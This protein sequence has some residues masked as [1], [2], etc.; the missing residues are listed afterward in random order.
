M[1]H[2][3]LVEALCSDRIPAE[4]PANELS[5]H[6]ILLQLQDNPE[7][8]SQYQRLV[9]KWRREH[10][11]FWSGRMFD[12][13]AEQSTGSES[14]APATLLSGRDGHSAANS[15]SSR[16]QQPKKILRRAVRRHIPSTPSSPSRLRRAPCES[17]EGVRSEVNVGGSSPTSM[18]YRSEKS[19]EFLFTAV[20]TS[21]TGS[22]RSS[23]SGER[24]SQRTSHSASTSRRG[25]GGGREQ[26]TLAVRQQDS[27]GSNSGAILPAFGLNFDRQ[28]VAQA[29]AAGGGMAAL[30]VRTEI[31][32]MQGATVALQAAGGVLAVGLLGYKRGFAAGAALGTVA[33]PV[34]AL[35]GGVCGALLASEAVFRLSNALFGDDRERALGKAYETLG[36]APTAKDE[37]VRKK[38]L[39]LA[40]ANHPDKGGN[41][42]KFIEIN[43]AYELIRAA[44]LEAAFRRAREAAAPREEGEEVVVEE[45]SPKR[46]KSGGNA[47]KGGEVPKGNSS[48]SPTRYASA[49]SSSSASASSSSASP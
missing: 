3:G 37:Q 9:E 17:S 48:T 38:Y 16:Q 19:Q 28:Q 41:E 46:K 35:A 27:Q 2:R 26:N 10:Q 12:H 25:S 32:A 14:S 15:A 22:T 44:R 33:G 21:P 34:G 39:K 24:T 8:R 40:K 6:A 49:A 5:S 11:E 36:V 29:A 18:R 1:E 47:A 30:C 43:G 45:S 31:G 13:T 20:E 4:N 7:K 23:T 42:A